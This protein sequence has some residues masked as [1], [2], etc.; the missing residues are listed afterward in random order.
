MIIKTILPQKRKTFTKTNFI[1]HFRKF[2]KSFNVNSSSEVEYLLIQY[3]LVYNENLL[4][5]LTDTVIID[6]NNKDDVR[7]FKEYILLNFDILISK[8]LKQVNKIYICYK[9]SNSDAYNKYREEIN[10]TNN[11]NVGPV[12]LINSL[13]RSTH[14]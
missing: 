6:L 3:K 2:I 4:S 11:L 7:N 14:I 1:E 5:N 8:G 9:I 10:N 12:D 13:L